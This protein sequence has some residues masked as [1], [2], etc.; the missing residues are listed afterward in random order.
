MLNYLSHYNNQIIRIFQ[1]L[2]G[3]M[4]WLH[5][6]R[7]HFVLLGVSDFVNSCLLNKFLLIS[8]WFSNVA[9]TTCIVNSYFWAYVKLNQCQSV[10]IMVY[11]FKYLF[12]FSLMKCFCIHMECIWSF[13]WCH[14]SPGSRMMTNALFPFWL[15]LFFVLFLI[16]YETDEFMCH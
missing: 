11:R 13:Y 10:S 1:D 6:F 7:F 2:E 9:M 8:F 4:D 12:D 3:F 15:A 5:K 14:L 16:A